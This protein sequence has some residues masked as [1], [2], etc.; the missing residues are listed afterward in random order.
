M[1]SYSLPK[2]F[3]IG[4][5]KCGTTSL[6]YLFKHNNIKSKMCGGKDKNVI[7]SY[8]IYMNIMFSR[9]P[10]YNLEQYDAFSD[11]IY[12][13]NYTYIEVNRLTPILYNYYPN[14][15]FILNT[16]NIDSWLKSR[17]KHGQGSLV[18]R[19]CNILNCTP[20]ELERFWREQFINHEKEIISYFNKIHGKLLV[21]D[22]EKDGV[23]HIANF[24]KQD[25]EI[26]VSHWNI[27]NKTKT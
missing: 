24:L 10:L 12:L 20:H 13:D 1:N 23:S 22:I 19:C 18:S 8:K 14:S 5:N 17:F 26:D 2:I 9:D 3:V 11:L 4:F 16:R 25:Y 6:H 27:Y 15:Y 21:F 7:L